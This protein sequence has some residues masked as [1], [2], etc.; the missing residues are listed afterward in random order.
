[1]LLRS[2]KGLF[3]LDIDDRSILLFGITVAV[4]A[5]LLLGLAVAVSMAVV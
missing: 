4:W 5:G 3:E 1:M 2:S